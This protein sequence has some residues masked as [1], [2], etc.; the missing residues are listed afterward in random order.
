MLFAIKLGHGKQ[1]AIPKIARRRQP[2][3]SVP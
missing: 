2:V 1:A 3:I